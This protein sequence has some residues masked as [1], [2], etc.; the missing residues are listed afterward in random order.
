MNEL[1]DIKTMLVAAV[2]DIEA[3]GEKKTKVASAGIRKSLGE[4]KKKVTAVRA[5]LVAEDKA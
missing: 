1:N 4:I 3:Y 5:A 2:A